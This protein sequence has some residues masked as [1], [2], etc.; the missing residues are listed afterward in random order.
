[1]KSIR[2]SQ[3]RRRDEKCRGPDDCRRLH[4]LRHQVAL[5]EAVEG[6]ARD[7]P[8]LIAGLERLRQAISG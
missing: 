1:M 6:G 7:G 4:A 2:S 3:Q 5:Q 8:H